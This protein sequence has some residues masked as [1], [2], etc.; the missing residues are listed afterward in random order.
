LRRLATSRGS[1]PDFVP[2]SPPPS[3]SFGISAA[4][5]RTAFAIPFLNEDIPLYIDPFLL[6]RS[7]SQHENALHNL[8]VD[9][10]D[11]VGHAALAGN[12]DDAVR[13]LVRASECDEVGLGVSANR[14][15]KRIGS[16]TAEAIL[17]T[18]AR[19][20]GFRE[21]GMRHVE[22]LQLL[23]D[24]ISRD[25]ISD[26]AGSVLKDHLVDFTM[27]ECEKL[28]VPTSEVV[29]D[30]VYDHKAHQFKSETAKLPVNPLN[31][32]PILLAPKRW[33]RHVPWI[34]YDSYFKTACPHDDIAHEGAPLTRARVLDFNRANFGLV[35]RYVETRERTAAD[36]QAD[37][38]FTQLP[39]LSAK[40][41]LEEIRKLPTGRA[42]GVD[43]RYEDALTALLPT[44]L[45]PDLDFAEA[46][47]RTES[48]VSIRDLIFYNTRVEPFLADLGRDYDSRQIVFEM[49]NVQS[50]SS[51]DI[52]QLHRYLPPAL[53]RFGVIVTRSELPSARQKQVVDLWSSRRV[54]IIWIT[55]EDLAQMVEVFETKQRK[56]V[57]V[58]NKKYVEFQRLLPN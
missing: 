58:L 47:A 11:R 20:P 27:S 29:L 31:G 2:D 18:L 32:K 13:F 24:G 34:A 9:A 15:G 5:E 46:Q 54:A 43:K 14:A 57:E 53:G 49:K 16:A 37:P 55:D 38:L 45:Y 35:S 19:L 26:F 56:P 7:P 36:C 10:F 44:L 1:V 4:Q 21:R 3:R 25:R 42:G 17:D 22:I 50:V 33:L 41:K 8:L 51:E 12:R 28:A 48:G 52:D 30:D 23:V 6:W 40:R 39:V